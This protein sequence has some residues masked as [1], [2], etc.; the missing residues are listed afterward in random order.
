MFGLLLKKRLFKPSKHF[1]AFFEVSYKS[2]N[3]FHSIENKICNPKNVSVKNSKIPASN[4]LTKHFSSDV[5]FK[6]QLNTENSHSKYL[7][8]MSLKFDR[9]YSNGDNLIKGVDNYLNESFAA[10]KAKQLRNS[11]KN[12]LHNV[13]DVVSS[14]LNRKD[15]KL[16]PNYKLTHLSKNKPMWMCTYNLHWPEDIKF[17]GM[18]STK[19]E[20]SHKAALNALLWLRKNNKI[21]EQGRPN[22]LK[23]EDILDIKK[24]QALILKDDE[25]EKL[26]NVI[27]IYHKDL[28]DVV[29]DVM[30]NKSNSE[31]EQKIKEYE[32]SWPVLENEIKENCLDSLVHKDLKELPISK[33][34]QVIDYFILFLI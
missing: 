11:S 12:V 17:S 5:L 26:Q 20:A 4:Y 14:E 34:R 9:C 7:C 29:N 23:T 27:D 18:A 30:K 21:N 2:N 3:L 28:E 24:P 15:L 10:D 33:Y 25:I 32:N 19:Q 22:L 1:L 16:N 8:C 6:N 13:F 31:D